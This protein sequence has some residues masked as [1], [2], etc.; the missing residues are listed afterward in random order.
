[1]NIEML[2][3]IV[4]MTVQCAGQR[5]LHSGEWVVCSIAMTMKLARRFSQARLGCSAIAF[6]ALLEGQNLHSCFA[7]S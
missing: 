5:F 3:A 2:V 7:A 6:L 4:E 1:M